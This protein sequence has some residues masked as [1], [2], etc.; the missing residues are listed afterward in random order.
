LHGTVAV[1][2]AFVRGVAYVRRYLQV[3]GKV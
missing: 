3:F 1:A 2:R